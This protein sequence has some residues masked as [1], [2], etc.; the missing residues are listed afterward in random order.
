MD[1]VR[2]ELQKMLGYQPLTG[3]EPFMEGLTL[4]EYLALPEEEQ[5]R[6]WNK[7]EGFLYDLDEVELQNPNIDTSEALRDAVPA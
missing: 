3:D 6:L 1:K 2:S 5:A 7:W 4:N